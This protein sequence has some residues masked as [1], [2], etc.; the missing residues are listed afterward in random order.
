MARKVKCCVS[1]KWGTSDT[2]LKIDGKYYENE[3]VYN[4][5]KRMS[6]CWKLTIDKITIDF[7]GYKK[8]E[9]YP[10]ILNKRLKSLDFYDNEVIYRTVLFSEEAILYALRTKEFDSTYMKIQYIMAILRNNIAK[11]W[12][13]VR[14]ERKAAKAEHRQLE[15]IVYIESLDNVEN[16]KQIN[17]DISKFVE[18]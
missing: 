9:P 8:G 1:G 4:W 7:L 10:T 3:E 6:N 12:K 15:D 17:K 16:P 14:E 11:V 13:T 5:Q 2:F 18:D